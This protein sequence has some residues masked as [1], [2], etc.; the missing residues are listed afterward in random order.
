ML[1]KTYMISSGSIRPA[2]EETSAVMPLDPGPV[3]PSAWSDAELTEAIVTVC[4]ESQF[5]PMLAC[6][7]A[8]DHCRRLTPR[9]TTESLRAAMRARLSGSMSVPTSI[10]LKAA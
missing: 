9:G 3:S 1:M 6:W 2:G 8:L 4:D 7:R 5:A 10:S